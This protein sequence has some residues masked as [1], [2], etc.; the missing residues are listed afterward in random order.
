M[1]PLSRKLRAVGFETNISCGRLSIHLALLAAV[2]AGSRLLPA[3]NNSF[4]QFPD[5]RLVVTMIDRKIIVANGG[6]IFD[7][8]RCALTSSRGGA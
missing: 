2:I 1:V 5:A 4:D 3:S 7:S 8:R 6:G